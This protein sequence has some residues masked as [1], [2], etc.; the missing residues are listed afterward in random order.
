ME[1]ITIDSKAYKELNEKLDEIYLE[2]KR[3]NSPK[4]QL[5]NEWLSA[6][7][8]EKLLGVCQKTRVN[9]QNSGLLKPKRIKRRVYYRLEEVQ[10][11]LG[12]NGNPEKTFS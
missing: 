6:A 10:E 12:K 8:V 9:Y 3:I 7:E 1:V 5:Y 2:L 4:E 11:L